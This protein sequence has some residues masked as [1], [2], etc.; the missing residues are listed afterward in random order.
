LRGTVY[1]KNE[2]LLMLKMA[3]FRE[4]SVRGDFTDQAATADSKELVFTAV[5]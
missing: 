5:K 4:I 2:I 1:F 3:G